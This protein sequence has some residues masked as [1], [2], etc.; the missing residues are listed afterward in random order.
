MT[1]DISRVVRGPDRWA[2]T[3]GD[4]LAFLRS[5]PTGCASVCVT[6]PPYE[7]ARTYSMGFALRGQEW[8]DWFRPIV[9][10]ACR[11]TAG[12]VCVVA[13]GQVRDFRYSPIMELLTADLVRLDGVVM[14]PQPYAWTKNA[15]IAGSGNKHY[16]RR[17]WEPVYCYARPAHLPVRWSDNTAFGKP[18]KWAPGGEM[19][20]RTTKGTRVNQWGKTWD[21][22]RTGKKGEKPASVK[23]QRPSHKLITRPREGMYSQESTT[24]T[25]PAIANPGNVIHTNVGG[26]QLGHK[27]AHENEAPF[28]VALAE[29]FV[30]WF[31]PPGGLVIDP[32]AGSSTT[33]HAAVVHGR[34]YIGCDLRQSQVELSRRR[35]ADV[36]A[37]LEAAHAPATAPTAEGRP[38]DGG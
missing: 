36:L 26:N 5:L 12:L 30:R 8:V 2:V 3:Q 6:S 19:S 20:H 10:E 14:G 16:H 7:A 33:G 4:A 35:I 27:L 15:G 18:P 17:D 13:A 29:R 34:R 22:A 31:C 38:G 25:P 28:P 1:P 32:F 24:Y 37:T 9:T 21:T 23:G 11:V